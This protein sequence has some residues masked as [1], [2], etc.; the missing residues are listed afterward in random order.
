[1]HDRAFLL[2]ITKLS[3]TWGLAQDFP[4]FSLDICQMLELGGFSLPVELWSPFFTFTGLNT[5]KFEKW[6]HTSGFYMLPWGSLRI[7]RQD[8]N[9]LNKIK[10]LTTQKP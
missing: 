5:L 6:K 7:K 9:A 8:K 2:Q 4:L 10:I 1:M 3:D